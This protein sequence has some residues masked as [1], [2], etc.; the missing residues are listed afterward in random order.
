MAAMTDEKIIDLLKTGSHDKAVKQLYKHFNM[1]K[2][3]IL[4]SG[5]SKADAEETFHDSLLLLCEKVVQPDFKLTSSLSTYLYG[6]N[7]F[8]WLNKQRKNSRTT[9]LEWRD[10]LILTS[11]DL[12][13]SE[14][15]EE[16]FKQLEAILE[17]ISEK[18]K[19]ILE[20]FYL[21]KKR[22][23]EISEILGFSSVNSAKTQKYKCLERA[24]SLVPKNEMQD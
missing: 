8:L 11:E 13:Y 9:E 10:T 3:N 15:K 24:I 14:E 4:K 7:R 6:I 2:T 5:G 19:K 21:K 18:C 16:K 1:V 20:L 17:S 22:M 12:N 23:T